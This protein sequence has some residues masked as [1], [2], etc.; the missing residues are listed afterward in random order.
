MDVGARVRARSER[1]RKTQSGAS[2]RRSRGAVLA[3]GI[4]LLIGQWSCAKP[5]APTLTPEVAR[6][7]AV[8]MRGLDLDVQVRVH[9]PNSFPLAAHAVT[10][11][12]FVG[13]EQELGRGS[14]TPNGSIPANG[15]SVVQTRVRVGWQN[16]TALTPFMAYE[17]LPYTFRGEV[18]LGN[19][20]FNVS[21]PFTLQ[22]TLSRAELLRAGM[23]GF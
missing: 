9:N 3:L 8:D 18:A 1:S 6:V 7:A 15:S 22:G 16:L 19:D 14:A 13:S 20:T 11:T 23:R 2:I 10:G 12:V 4:A 17:S 5:Q 21:V